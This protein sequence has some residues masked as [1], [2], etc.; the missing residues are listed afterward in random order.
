MSGTE[1][2][3]VF[4]IFLSSFG[5]ILFFALAVVLFTVVY[6]KRFIRQQAK[7]RKMEQDWQQSLLHALLDQ[8][9]SERSRIARDLHD[10][11]GP[12]LS[13][14]KF[15]ISG[16]KAGLLDPAALADE[17]NACLTDAIA[18]VRTLAHDLMPPELESLGLV[19]SIQQ[20]AQRT[21]QTSGIDIALDLPASIPLQGPQALNFYRIVQELIANMLRHSHAQQMRLASTIESGQLILNYQDNGRGFELPATSQPQEGI[22]LKNIHARASRLGATPQFLST[23]GQGLQFKMCIPLTLQP[24]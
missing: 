14:A 17:G 3:S 15:A 16:M 5:I 19:A 18:R 2:Q 20:L 24:A 11:L 6:Q 22:G 13:A 12:L 1:S 4:I 21:A 10:D 7:L 8:Q 23:P 9:E